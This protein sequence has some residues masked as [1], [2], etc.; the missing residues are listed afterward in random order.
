MS[1]TKTKV[2][3][4]LLIVLLLSASIFALYKFVLSEQSSEIPEEVVCDHKNFTYSYDAKPTCTQQGI[5]KKMCK[6]CGVLLRTETLPSLGHNYVDGVCTR[7]GGVDPDYVAPCEHKNEKQVVTTIATCISDGVESYYCADCDILLRT[8]TIPSLGHN[9]VDGV[10]TRCGGVDPNYV[11]PCEH[12]NE[13]QEITTVSTCLASGIESYYCA[14][15][16]VLLR[17]ETLPATGHAFGDWQTTTEATCTESGVQTK[18]CANCSMQQTKTLL[19]LG[20]NYV[21][22]SCSRCGAFKY[23]DINMKSLK[24][25]QNVY[26]T[27]Q[28]HWTCGSKK[29]TDSEFQT[30]ASDYSYRPF[31]VGDKSHDSNPQSTKIIPGYAFNID[32][33]TKT[34]NAYVAVVVGYVDCTFK[35]K[36]DSFEMA[37][38]GVITIVAENFKQSLEFKDLICSCLSNN[39]KSRFWNVQAGSFVLKFQVSNPK[40][41]GSSLAVGAKILEC[42]CPIYYQGY[43]ND[44]DWTVIKNEVKYKKICDQ[45]GVSKYPYCS[46]AY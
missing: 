33:E 6:D 15:C 11:A 9:Y 44:Y 18:T 45:V 26:S 38:N 19:A 37:D 10:C 27:P 41:Y 25:S 22:G 46:I 20:H 17:T 5:C 14:D 21:D 13:R 42:D 29:M 24:L 31:V 2:I 36:F 34:I 12:K 8:E 30:Y 40:D 16:G 23:S 35:F 1:K 3:V 28:C 43:D 7:C 4:V 39:F 32:F